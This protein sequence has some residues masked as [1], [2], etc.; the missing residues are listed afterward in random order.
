M[1][2]SLLKGTIILTLAGLLTRV[3]GFIYKIYLSN[4]LEAKILGLYQLVFPVFGLCFTIFGAGIQTAISRM[5]AASSGN[6]KYIRKIL[7]IS[8]LLS[9]MIALILSIITFCGSDYIALRMLGEA[10]CAELLK[11]LA[12][13]FPP[14]AVAVCING[15]YYGLKKAS[16]PALSQLIEQI[17]RV[18]FVYIALIL[19]PLSDKYAM[20]MIA[21]A[22]IAVVEGISML[23]SIIMVCCMFRK[24]DD[25]NAEYS[26][27]DSD[28]V[29]KELVCFATPLTGNK[30][31]VALLHSI[32]TII[33]PT[34]LKNYGMTSD[35]ALSVYGVLTGMAMPF[36]M[37][38]S[39]ITNSLAVL[40]LPAVSEANQSVDNKLVKMSRLCIVIS[41][42]LG[43]AS[44]VIFLTIGADIGVYVFNNKSIGLFIKMLAF[45]CPFIFVSTTL[46]SI[47]NGL[48]KT[49]ITFFITA[50][51]LA[52]RIILTI[53]TVP[54]SGISG[55]LIS[56]LV[57]E[58]I[59]TAMS[60]HYYKKYVNNAHS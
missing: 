58:V 44:I 15:C 51:G 16:T 19:L 41:V 33:I 60:A 27:N 30:L 59:I 3:I 2:K 46:A 26:E 7:I 21:V 28:G 56:L 8:I 24:M 23:Y 38:P 6:K 20:C 45:L 40:L 13:A 29:F 36:V 35:E 9:V 47:I 55:Y 10:D 5:V 52:V 48:G 17:V 11:P 4:I 42:I 18:S 57:S 34:L 54:D 49:Y 32:E 31:I 50:T 14:C 39:T 22:G 43:V 37:F 1:I 53:K 12:F 25:C